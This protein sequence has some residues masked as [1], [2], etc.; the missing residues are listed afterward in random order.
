[1]ALEASHTRFALDLKEK[2][3]VND[4]EKY[5][6]GAN[7]PDSHLLTKLSRIQTHPADFLE[8]K[9]PELS[10]FKKGWF[11]HLLCDKIQAKVFQEKFPF[12]YKDE[13]PEYWNK[14][15]LAI[16]AIKALQDMEDLKMVDMSSV[17][18]GIDL[19]ENP[20]GED[21]D[22]LKKFYK[23]SEVFYLHPEEIT[24]INYYHKLIDVGISASIARNVLDKA[25][26]YSKNP[27]MM[28]SIKTIYNSM[29]AEA[30]N[31]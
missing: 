4:I 9:L 6:F 8:W 21:L 15:W 22:Q 5:I 24:V 17:W 11:T 29:I 7:Y 3:K 10:D 25:Q 14:S 16:T 20:N 19:I 18:T 1:M 2:Y 31:V 26:E 28:E 13:M 27:E 12:I 30:L 23:R